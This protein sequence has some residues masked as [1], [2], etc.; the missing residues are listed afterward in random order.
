M[1]TT[2]HI[3]YYRQKNSQNSA[4]ATST[5]AQWPFL[6]EKTSGGI[7]N[8]TKEKTGKKSYKF[9]YVSNNLSWEYTSGDI[10]EIVWL[11]HVEEQSRFQV[12]KSIQRL[13]KAELKTGA[14]TNNK[15][16]VA[17][18]SLKKKRHW[19]RMYLCVMCEKLHT[20]K[21]YVF[22]K[23]NSSAKCITVLRKQEIWAGFRRKAWEHG[24]LGFILTIF[25]NSVNKYGRNK[26]NTLFTVPGT[27]QM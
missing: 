22:C 13:V 15:H 23:S 21:I 3:L 1:R 14:A 25:L 11:K 6:Q 26:Q 9:F 7:K 24:V 19:L 20:V 4:A 17:W 16:T 10:S 27:T 2:K 5:A 12:S 18:I 8:I